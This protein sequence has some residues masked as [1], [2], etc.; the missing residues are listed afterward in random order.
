MKDK[1]RKVLK[2]LGKL[3]CSKEVCGRYSVITCYSVYF[4]LLFALMVFLL[5]VLSGMLRQLYQ[6]HGLRVPHEKVRQGRVG[7][8]EAPDEV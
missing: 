4:S 1:L 7:A 8:G 2:R 3:R 6:H 5:P